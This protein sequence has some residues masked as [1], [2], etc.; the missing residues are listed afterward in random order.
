MCVWGGG[1]GRDAC[2]GDTHTYVYTY[3]YMNKGSLLPSSY[4]GGGSGPE[5]GPVLR[6]GLLGLRARRVPGWVGGWM[7][8]WS[9]VG[10]LG[11][12]GGGMGGWMVRSIDIG[13]VRG[14]VGQMDR[15]SVVGLSG[16]GVL[17]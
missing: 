2:G 17:G 11:I 6:D 5:E 14:C 7:V 16:I 1:A 8:R 13:C 3:T 15:W 10:V 4:L 9:M 12:G